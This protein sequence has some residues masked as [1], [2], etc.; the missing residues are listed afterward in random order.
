MRIA[1]NN[2]MVA[3]VRN[4]HTFTTPYRLPNTNFFC[5]SLK[6]EKDTIY[7]VH[8]DSTDAAKRFRNGKKEVVDIISLDI[9]SDDNGGVLS[10]VYFGSKKTM[11]LYVARMVA[12]DAAELERKASEVEV[13]QVQTLESLASLDFGDL[14]EVVDAELE[15]KMQEF[16]D[17]YEIKTKAA[18][19]SAKNLL[20]EVAKFYLEQKYIDGNTYL[21]YKLEIEEQGLAALFFQLEVSLQASKHLSKQIFLGN[22]NVKQYEALAQLQRVILDVNKYRSQLF[23]EVVEDL[24]NIEQR[25]MIMESK[26]SEEGVEEGEEIGLSTP[27]RKTL[28]E[29]MKKFKESDKNEE[30]E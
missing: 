2:K 18:A 24:Q 17:A 15:A 22:A 14:P 26:S 12:A 6:R 3:V 30:E 11:D 4:M 21:K 28:I 27:S 29:Q 13:R 20:T 8:F 1:G 7:Q 16:E 23:K 25:S 10:S 19:Q 5:V 9:V